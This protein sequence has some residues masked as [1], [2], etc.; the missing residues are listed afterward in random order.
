MPTDTDL[1]PQGFLHHLARWMLIALAD[2]KHGKRAPAGRM[3][4]AAMQLLPLLLDDLHASELSGTFRPAALG[5]EKYSKEF[6]IELN[7]L[8]LEPLFDIMV[9]TGTALQA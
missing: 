5:Q 3:K 8:R 6:I 7:S 4:A 1:W 9:G 2:T